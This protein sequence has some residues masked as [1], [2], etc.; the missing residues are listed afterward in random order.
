MIEVINVTKEIRSKIATGSLIKNLFKPTYTTNCVLHDINLTVNQGDKIALIGRNGSGKSSLIKAICGITQPNTGSVLINGV[1]PSSDR[2]KAMQSMGVMFAQKSFLYPNLTLKD[3]ISLYASI[4][5]LC[6]EKEEH[7]YHSLNKF[8]EVDDFVSAQVRTLSFGQR[9]RG[10][11]ICALIHNPSLIILD[12]P[13]VGID[14]SSKQLLHRFLT[15]SSYMGDKT[16]IITSH[17]PQ[18][19]RDFATRC[20]ELTDGKVT[21]DGSTNDYNLG[22]SIGLK[23]SL[24]QPVEVMLARESDSGISS[25]NLSKDRIEVSFTPNMSEFAINQWI[26]K[27]VGIEN[28]ATLERV[29]KLYSEVK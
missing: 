13:T 20:V 8:F 2:K 22:I 26:V 23:I 7:N 5:G 11:L 27:Q 10:E 19:I 28:I 3:C 12:E 14:V 21:Y 24:N 29:E 17:E 18:I 25:L 15:D 1:S 16:V 4:R 9:I 6:N